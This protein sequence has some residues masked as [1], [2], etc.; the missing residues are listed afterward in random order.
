MVDLLFEVESVE[1][2]KFSASPL[3]LFQIRILNAAPQLRVR[4][5]MLN[6]QIR[7]E[8]TRRFY[9]D[10]EKERLAEL[11][12]EPERWGQTLHSFLW[13]HSSVAVPG[14]ESETRIRLPAPCTRDFSIASAK[15]FYGL[16]DGETP[17]NFLFSGSVFYQDEFGAL[18]IQQ[19][20][21]SKE[22][23]FRMPVT[24]WQRLMDSH[25]PGS[26]WLRLSRE[27]FERLYRYKRRRG[28]LTWEE[29][30]DDLLEAA[31]KNETTVKGLAQ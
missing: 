18:Q 14:F 27:T 9:S 11:F 7:I 1:A 3:L 22:T 4:N 10:D 12:G 15:Y 20:P 19:I 28:L 17:L 2:E 6:C 30:V 23:A 8:P 29:A 25:Y 24:V 5:I 31:A 16:V 13:T 21:W 26:D